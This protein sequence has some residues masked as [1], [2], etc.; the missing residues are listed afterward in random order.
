MLPGSSKRVRIRDRKSSVFVLNQPASSRQNARRQMLPGKILRISPSLIVQF[1]THQF[2]GPVLNW[3]RY[4]LSNRSY[5]AANGSNSSTITPVTC[6]VLHGSTLSPIL[7]AILTS[8]VAA[9]LSVPSRSTT[10]CWWHS[11]SCSLGVFKIA[12]VSRQTWFL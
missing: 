8:P 9:S 6:A 2:S 5:S 7:F 12:S 1:F 4:Y 10:V 11:S 3:I